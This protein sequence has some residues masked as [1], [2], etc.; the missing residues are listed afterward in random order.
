MLREPRK[1]I[2]SKD[3]LSPVAQIIFWQRNAGLRFFG[4]LVHRRSLWSDGKKIVIGN[5]PNILI[6]AIIFGLRA[7]GAAVV[8]I[9]IVVVFI[10]LRTVGLMKMSLVLNI[11][12]EI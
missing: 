6:S 2:A 10:A 8:V 11:C 12:P 9:I 4:T 1:K 5:G 7:L 3:D